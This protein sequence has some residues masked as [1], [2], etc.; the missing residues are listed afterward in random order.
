MVDDYITY[1]STCNNFAIYYLMLLIASRMTIFYSTKLRLY[2][3]FASRRCIF[4]IENQ[5]K[6]NI[7]DLSVSRFI[8]QRS[9]ISCHGMCYGIKLY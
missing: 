7:S 2:N 5:G 8:D 4:E 6:P 3:I 1:R 9:V